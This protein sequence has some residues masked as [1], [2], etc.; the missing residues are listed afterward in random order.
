VPFFTDIGLVERADGG[1]FTPSKEL[2]AYNKARQWSEA[3]A[4]EKLRP[5]FEKT[6]FYKCLVPRLQ[7][8]PQPITNCLAVLSEESKAQKD[9]EPRLRA[10]I[11]FLGLAGVVSVADGTVNFSQ[12]LSGSAHFSGHGTMAATGTVQKAAQQ[13]QCVHSYVLPLPNR[14]KV[15]VEAPL[16][17]TKAEISRLQ[18]WIEFTLLLD[19]KEEEKP[20]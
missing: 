8:A 14:R 1:K 9:H 5:L 7:L 6:W 10:L 4:R 13:D 11:E 18:K 17:I 15:V 3:E 16:D 19:W 2:V 12:N 20:Q